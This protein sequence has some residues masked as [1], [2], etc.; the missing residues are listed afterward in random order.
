MEMVES[1]KG[2]FMTEAIDLKKKDVIKKSARDLFIHFGFSKTS[3]EDIA[4]QSGLAKPT[5]YY[6]YPGKEAIFDEIVVEEAISFMNHVEQRLP[7]NL[8]ADAKLA[9]FF[10]TIYQDLKIYAAKMADLPAYL[11]EHSPHGHPIVVKIND[12][13][14][15]KLLPLLREGK[16][17]NIFDYEDEAYASS[18]LVFMTDFLNMDWIHHYPEEMCDRVVETMIEIMINGLKRRS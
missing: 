13:F 15:E 2:K 16:E 18:T 5:L 11:C 6:Y 1:L 7:E 17:E 12:L 14:K 10:R 4:R 8:P 3:M 9:F